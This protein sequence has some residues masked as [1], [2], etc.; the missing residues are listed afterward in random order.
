MAHRIL[1]LTHPFQ[2]D[3]FTWPGDPAFSMNAVPD[4]VGFH[5][6]ALRFS[7]HSGTHIGTAA[8]FDQ[9]GADVYSL[10]PEQLIISAVCIQVNAACEA[11]PDYL[12][13]IDDIIQWEA[14]KN[15][16]I[17]ENGV[18]LIAT[19]WYRFWSEPERYFGNPD[20]P[21]F[22]GIATETIQWLVQNRRI[23]GVGI[24]TAGVDGSR[25]INDLAANQLL[26]QKG[27]YHLENLANLRKLP[28]CVFTVYIGALPIPGA[29]GSPCRVLAHWED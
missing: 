7:D 13:Q 11:T 19:G 20:R 27:R 28:S 24:D 18:V 29:T 22:P 5:I 3:M 17:P 26:L 12:V 1:D 21:L 10:S 9:E 15:R 23:A 14:Q 25:G 8:H 4:T 6:N 16:A 2:P